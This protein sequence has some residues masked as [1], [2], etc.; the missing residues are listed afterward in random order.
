[1]I[2]EGWQL[3]SLFRN[4]LYLAVASCFK[5][6]LRD[7]MIYSNNFPKRLFQGF[8]LNYYMSYDFKNFKFLEY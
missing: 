6:K 4:I 3:I 8:L 7:N 1:M 2:K 5:E